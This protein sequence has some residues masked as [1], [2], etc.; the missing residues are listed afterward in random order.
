MNGLIGK[1]IGMTQYFAEDGKVVP[2][3]VIKVEK[4]IIVNIKN[5][6]RDGYNAIVCG[7]EELKENKVSKPMIGFFNKNS[8]KP[9]RY[10]KEFKINDVSSYSIGQEIGL[11]LFDNVKF[12]DVTGISK[13]KG[14][15]GVMK[16]H[17]FHGG[18]ASHGSKF[19]RENGS[20]GQN[21][22]PSKSFKGVKRAGRMGRE[23]V[24][25]QNLKVISKLEDGIL[26]VKGAIP[27]INKGIVI[28]KKAVKKA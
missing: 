14:F 27:G 28:I 15:Q 26:L 19:H 10:L 25:V 17:N 2:V 21:T 20:T 8:V 18:P 11:E 3:T 16:R 23:K 13:G 5:K 22:Y 4:N 12:V 6:E 1:K 24:T 7:I 9:M